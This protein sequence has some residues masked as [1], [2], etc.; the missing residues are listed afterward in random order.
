MPYKDRIYD[1]FCN[2]W[3][4]PTFAPNQLMFNH[5]V[6]KKSI[7]KLE[8][9]GGVCILYTHLGYYYKN[10]KVDEG[11]KKMISYIGKKIVVFFFPVS[12]VLD[13]IQQQKKQK[14]SQNIYLLKR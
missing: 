10:G 1:E 8:S 5:I 4:S 2:Y 9:E 14:I 12:D 7:D 13:I 3:Y 11:F 6:N